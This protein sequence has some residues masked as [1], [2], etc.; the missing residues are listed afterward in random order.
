M[1]IANSPIQFGVVCTGDSPRPLGPT[2]AANLALA[3]Q[4]LNI[5]RLTLRGAPT[6]SNQL[7]P[8]TTLSL[9]HQKLL[10]NFQYHQTKGSSEISY[11]DLVALQAETF[12]YLTTTGLNVTG[13]SLGGTVSNVL[14]RDMSADVAY[15]VTLAGGAKQL[16][17][18][19]S[20]TLDSITISSQAV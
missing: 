13:D 17:Q 9:A 11:T 6:L 15:E 8:L 19:W 4:R 1:N 10:N 20:M 16:V 5:A 18:T 12:S 2:S 14:I 3:N 7:Y